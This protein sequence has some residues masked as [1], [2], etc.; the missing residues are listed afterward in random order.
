MADLQ[1][2]AAKVSSLARAL[3]GSVDLKHDVPAVPK[4]NPMKGFETLV[5]ASSKDVSPSVVE[6]HNITLPKMGQIV[7]VFVEYEYTG[8]STN[9][10]KTDSTHHLYAAREGPAFAQT[11]MVRLLSNS[12]ELARM[13]SQD[14]LIKIKGMP[15]ETRDALLRMAGEHLHQD[16]YMK[17]VKGT[18]P[19]LIKFNEA[20]KR[21]IRVLCPLP[22]A[23]AFPGSGAAGQIDASFLEELQ[24]EVKTRPISEAWA[25]LGAGSTIPTKCSVKLV[26]NYS[27]MDDKQRQK[28]IASA[29]KPGKPLQILSTSYELIGTSDP[30]TK[31]ANITAQAHE[32]DGDSYKPH[33]FNFRSSSSCMARSISYYVV[34]D[35]GQTINGF[36][37]GLGTAA[38]EVARPVGCLVGQLFKLRR[39]NKF[40]PIRRVEFRSGGR[41]VFDMTPERAL[42]ASLDR[43]YG[44]DNKGAVDDTLGSHLTYRFAKDDDTSRF[45][46]A[47]AMAGLSS[48]EHTVEADIR[49]LEGAITGSSLQ[50]NGTV[51]SAQGAD[52]ATTLFDSTM[53]YRAY[54][55]AEKVVVYSISPS[56]GSIKVSLST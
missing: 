17:P 53:I 10:G 31:P 3:E 15:A 52:N 22:F 24:I 56:D 35:E 19:L 4:S 33:T 6:T 26:V 27:Q 45:S 13:T 36:K 30:F 55:V 51:G 23:C 11:E 25:V 46:G 16:K 42:A 37:N 49:R 1:L 18:D 41:V 43:R 54:A 12:R 44:A 20:N 47:L 32:N 39:G 14:I 8:A 9:A 2:Q 29:Y 7:S 48:Q 50:A 21:T 5:I 34:A 38:G 28:M 40:Q